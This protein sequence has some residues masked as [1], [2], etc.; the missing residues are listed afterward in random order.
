MISSLLLILRFVTSSRVTVCSKSLF[1]N[2]SV[3]SRSEF[4]LDTITVDASLSLVSAT[5]F[6]V[7]LV[8]EDT[9]DK[10]LLFPCAVEHPVSRM[11]TNI[12]TAIIFVL[13][14]FII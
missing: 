4:S 12:I 6:V 2:N 7:T 11:S 1:V 3:T 13:F 14:F 8:S 5:S 10:I 9:I